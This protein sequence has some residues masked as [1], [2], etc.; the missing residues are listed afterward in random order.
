MIIVGFYKGHN[1]TACLLKDGKIIAAASEER[2]NRVKNS[3][4]FPKKAIEYCLEEAGIKATD[5]D[6]FVRT[7]RHP[8]GYIAPDG[9]TKSS[10][11]LTLLFSPVVYLRKFLFYFPSAHDVVIRIYNYF[12]EKFLVPNF[13]NHFR[14]NM[15]LFL[16]VDP[17]KIV[18]ADHHL[19]HAYA[20][21]YGF[22]EKVN[23]K[24][25]Y[26]V[27]TVD[28]EGDGICATVSAVKK[29]VWKR[30]S[31]TVGGNSIATFYG[32]ITQFLGM[33][34]NEHEYKVMGLAPYVSKFEMEKVYPL[35]NGLFWIDRGLVFH[36]RIPSGSLGEYFKRVLCYKRFD[37]VAAASQ[38]Y[39]ENI[40]CEFIKRAIKKSGI[41]KVVL[42]GGFF[43]NVKANKTISEL[44]EVSEI[45]PCP[46]AG[47]ESTVFGAAYWGYEKLCKEKRKD[48]CPL[49]ILGLY[50]GPNFD[51]FD[52]DLVLKDRLIKR[53][54]KIE[55][56]SNI[57]KKVANLLA[58]GKIVARFKG[59]MEWGARALGNRSILM[60]PRRVDLK[61][62]LN[63]QVKSRDFW[64]PFAASILEENAT[65]YLVNPKKVDGSFMIMAFDTTLKGREHLAAAIHPQDFTCR[66]QIVKNTVNS[67]YCG[68]IREFKKKT[69]VG[70]V[71]NTSFNYHGEPIVCSPSDA[72]NTFKLTGL[73]YLALDN[74]LIIKR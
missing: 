19:C 61:R 55:R 11:F 20:A 51:K 15:S 28:G 65:K 59:R 9:E 40:V 23:D 27:V 64:M 14:K 50:L 29:G 72:L 63:E 36:T 25:D 46:S 48:F 1:A 71:L 67:E 8:E 16:G 21:Y 32:L 35:F 49:P 17:R 24:K 74:Y 5:V 42:G 31:K 44:N 13:Q 62:E 26:L 43:M 34:M 69:G 3:D 70:A 47:D 12:S 60:D 18:F 53:K 57:D 6:L 73:K 10:F 68:L 30:I 2:F 22:V 58:Q 66:P 39:V 38:A 4:T 45:I 56:V 37:G 41:D 52:V 54:Y 7:Y 33:K